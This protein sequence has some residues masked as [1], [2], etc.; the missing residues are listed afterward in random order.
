MHELVVVDLRPSIA[1]RVELLERLRDLLHHDA[2]AHEAVERDPAIRVRRHAG[3]ASRASA[4]VN[5]YPVRGDRLA[6]VSIE[7]RN[8]AW[9][10]EQEQERG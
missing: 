6:I 9:D 5:V 10:G 7:N 2:R 3:A 1:V 8:G 4:L